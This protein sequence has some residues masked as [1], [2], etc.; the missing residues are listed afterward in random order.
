[1]SNVWG[2][3]FNPPQEEGV[4]DAVQAEG[5][6]DIVYP[7]DMKFEAPSQ[8]KIMPDAVRSEEQTDIV[9]PWDMKFNPPSNIADTQW[10]VMR[11]WDMKF[12]APVD[13]ISPGQYEP[14]PE[15]ALSLYEQGRQAANE[16]KVQEVDFMTRL[17]A[18]YEG[19]K[20]SFG[21]GME[22]IGVLAESVTG[23]SYEVTK[24]LQSEGRDIRQAATHRLQDFKLDP[25]SE[26]KACG[27]SL[28]LN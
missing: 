14:P 24:W 17:E 19:T 16:G 4:P 25:I 23:E 13:Q 27:F 12:N 6:T 22:T 10:D 28:W 9:Y 20:Q 1:M 3:E 15:S 7:W 5:Q 2:I 11:P 18:G 26:T 8:E 21:R